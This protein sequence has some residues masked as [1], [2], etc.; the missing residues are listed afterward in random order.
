[1]HGEPPVVLP[2][3]HHCAGL[4]RV[5]MVRR[6]LEGKIDLVLGAL[7]LALGVADLDLPGVAG[8]DFLAV[9]GTVLAL[10]QR[11]GRAVLRRRVADAHERRRR[12][13][14]LQRVGN[15][16]ADALAAIVQDVVL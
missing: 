16:H 2:Y 11:E 15:Q 1:M 14:V 12:A 8:A 9:L 6:R 5:V 3:G 7:V 10:L 4:H 13:R